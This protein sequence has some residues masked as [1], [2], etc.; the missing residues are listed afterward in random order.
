MKRTNKTISMGN[1]M[2]IIEV[3]GVRQWYST[4]TPV[5]STI[6]NCSVMTRPKYGR[7]SDENRN[8]E[9]S[10]SVSSHWPLTYQASRQP[11]LIS[12]LSVKLCPEDNP[13]TIGGKT[14]HHSVLAFP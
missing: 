10:M 14:S 4:G 11:A 12:L 13:I 3:S 1:I 5:F 8:S 2:P 7:K 6:Y 9:V